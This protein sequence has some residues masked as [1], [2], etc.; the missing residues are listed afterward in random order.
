MSAREVAR[1]IGVWSLV[2]IFFAGTATVAVTVPGAWW[3]LVGFAAYPIVGAVI[4]VARPRNAVGWLLLAVS[5]PWGPIAAVSAS[6]EAAPAWLELVAAVV[7]PVSLFAVPAIVIAFPSGRATTRAGRALGVAI[8]VSAGVVAAARVLSAAPL[9]T[10][11][12]PSPTATGLLGEVDGVMVGWA[13]TY[14]VAALL[15]AAL[16]ELIVRWRRSSGAERLQFRWFAFG[17][18]LALGVV[19][20]TILA[21]PFLPAESTAVDPLAF[22]TAVLIN[23]IP[24]CIGIA[25]TRHG[26]YAIGRVIS[27]TVSYAVVSLVAIAVYAVAVTSVTWLL[28]EASSVAVAAA[29]LAAAAVFL[30]LLRAVQRL[31]DRRFDREGYDA[32]KVVDAFGE[33]LRTGVDPAATTAGLVGAVETTLQPASVGLWIPSGRR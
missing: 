25:V 7:Q 12:R 18:A 21:A 31:L 1:R 22:A 4:V 33:R 14:A 23:A 16:A 3:P 5:V 6:A 19:L 20:F 13:G 9:E 17:V 10:T 32:Q 15:I 27:R 28:P 30:P 26:L 29:T 24:V 2:A 8:A 11:G